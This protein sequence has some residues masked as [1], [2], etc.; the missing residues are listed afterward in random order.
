M[1]KTVGIKIE[2]KAFDATLS[3][4]ESPPWSMSL[5]LNNGLIADSDGADLFDALAGLRNKLAEQNMLIVCYGARRN[6]YPSSMSRSM[7]AGVMAYQLSLGKQARRTDMVNIFDKCDD[8][9]IVTPE[10]QK[11]FYTLWLDSLKG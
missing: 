3:Y 4:A 9:E 7:G 10:E 8:S 2:D 1:E 6:V 5:Y 11:A